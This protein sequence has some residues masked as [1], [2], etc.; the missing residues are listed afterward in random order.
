MLEISYDIDGDGNSLAQQ[1]RQA[2]KEVIATGRCGL[3]IDYPVVKREEGDDE[4][5]VTVKRAREENLRPYIKVYDAQD[6]VNWVTKK[7]GALSILKTIILREECEEESSLLSVDTTEQYRVLTIEDGY[8]CQYIYD[9]CGDNSVQR[10]YENPIHP[11]DAN[12]NKLTKL[13][14]VF[15]GSENNDY[16]VD[17]APMEDLCDVNIS[18]YINSADNEES[19][20]MCGQPSLFVFASNPSLIK[21]ENPLGV[22][23]GARSVN[24]FSHEDSVEMLQA[25]PNSLPRQNMTDKLDMMVMLGARLITPSQQETAEAARIKHSGDNSALG[26]IVKNVDDAYTRA[27]EFLQLF[28]TAK[29]EEFIFQLNNDF[30]FEKMTSEDRTAW[31][32]DIVQGIVSK[33]DY[34]R[35]L[36]EGGLLADERS[37]EDIDSDIS[38]DEPVSLINPLPVNDFNA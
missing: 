23:V 33:S 29:E 20:F 24:I 13:P 30:F 9:L 16:N 11:L 26:I 12:G 22:K 8:Y 2:I 35:A 3:L 31:L 25:D 14:F 38:I 18:H 17:P 19:S 1:S 21:E 15:I 4:T 28:A 34:R 5:S 7:V 10:R 27:I 37:D 6:I 36:R 32:A